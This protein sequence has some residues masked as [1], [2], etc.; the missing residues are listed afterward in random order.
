M[1]PSAGSVL[2]FSSARALAP[3][4]YRRLRRGR[5]IMA[6]SKSSCPALC[7]ASTSSTL[8]RKTWMAGSSQ[9]FE[10]TPLVACATTRRLYADGTHKASFPERLIAGYRTF[11]SQRLLTEQSRYRELSERGQRPR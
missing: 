10:G 1:I 4:M 6:L 11:A 9:R 5:I 7:L 3:G 2:A 8:R